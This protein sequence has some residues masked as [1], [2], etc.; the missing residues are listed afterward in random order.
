MSAVCHADCVKDALINGRDAGTFAET[1]DNLHRASLPQH[2]RVLLQVFYTASLG[3]P[4]CRIHQL[5]LPHSSAVDITAISLLHCIHVSIPHHT[6]T[7][8]HRPELRTAQHF[9]GQLFKAQ[10]STA[11][12]V[13]CD[14]RSAKCGLLM[15]LMVG[16]QHTR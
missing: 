12:L 15:C 13:R 14:V 2:C 9:T 4:L 8:I 11:Q 5:S 10:L 1:A 7:T 6:A 16:F 3:S